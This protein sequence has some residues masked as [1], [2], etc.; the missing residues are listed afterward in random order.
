[1]G[2]MNPA[3]P[4]LPLHLGGLHPFEQL[5]VLLVAFGPFVVLFVVV[6]V[7]RRRDMTDQQDE[8]GEGAS[9]RRPARRDRPAPR[10]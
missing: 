7:V 8:P 6:Y 4:A 9:G 2:V 3:L 1:M 5:I 10:S